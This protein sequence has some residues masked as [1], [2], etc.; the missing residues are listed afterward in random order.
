M[1]SYIDRDLAV[2]GTYTQNLIDWRPRKRLFMAKRMAFLVDHLKSDPIEWR[3]RN[4]AALKEVHVRA[5][6]RIH[7]LLEKHQDAIRDRFIE[8]LVA[9]PDAAARF[10]SYQTVSRQVSEWRFTVALRH[11]LSS[12]R[13]EERG[14]FLGYCRDFAAKR[15]R[16]GFGP[17]EVIGALQ[18][19][20]RSCLEVLQEDPEGRGLDEALE[21]HLTM[22]ID[23]GCD[24]ILEVFEDLSGEEIDLDF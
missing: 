23:F 16:E 4:Q 21:K 12:V 18:G 5:N 6:L 13:T 15:F 14:L 17:R 1:V 3:Q 22:T 20:N 24:Q 19:L 10:P 8:T 7:R 11:I 2:D 9:G